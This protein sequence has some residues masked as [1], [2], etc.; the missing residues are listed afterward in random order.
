MNS[1]TK[2]FHQ[3][4]LELI[5]AFLPVAFIYYIIYQF[6]IGLIWPAV[7][8]APVAIAIGTYY[9]LTF[10]TLTVDP[11][12]LTIK[13]QEN[14]KKIQWDDIVSMATVKTYN[15]LTKYQIRTKNDER[16]T[17]FSALG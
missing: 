3:S 13:D 15:K 7:I 14:T 16:Y 8:T 10:K 5:F 6:N 17:S 12:G 2:V 1:D 4:Y 9:Y 11:S